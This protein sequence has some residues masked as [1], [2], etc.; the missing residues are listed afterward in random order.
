M[1]RWDP[2]LPETAEVHVWPGTFDSLMTEA[3]DQLD[4]QQT[5][6]APALV[7][8]D[9]FG[10][11][12]IPIDVIKRILGNEKCEVYVTFMWEAINRH[13]GAPEFEGHLN[14]LFGTDGWKDAIRLEGRERKLF[15]HRLY[16]QK[17]KAAGARQV[18]RFHLLKGKRLKYSIF[19]G[20][21][22][23]LGSDRMKEAIWKA[24]PSGDYNFRGGE[25]AQISFLEPNFAPLQE[26]LR[27]RFEAAGWVSIKR[28]EEFVRSDATIYYAG[29]LRSHALL[30]MERA[31]RIE[32]KVN[33][34]VRKKGSTYPKTC[35]INFRP[36]AP[37]FL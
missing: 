22:H 14:Q 37:R 35:R 18:V 19:F 16:R 3:L 8:M 25:Q 4:R 5:R 24:D 11:K 34:R 29:Q 7:M 32:V 27:E 15:L 2:K 6:M 30:P 17:L 36:E 1:D 13:I 21:G 33:E 28:I 10:V 23:T 9:P 20:T 26:A 12:G 31:G